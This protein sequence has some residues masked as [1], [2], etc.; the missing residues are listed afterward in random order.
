MFASLYLKPCSISSQNEEISISEGLQLIRE[1][2]MCTAQ[3]CSIE[4]LGELWVWESSGLHTRVWSQVTKNSYLLFHPE[5]PQRSFWAVILL[6][7]SPF[8]VTRL[9]H[10]VHSSADVHSLRQSPP[11]TT[12][13]INRYSSIDT[14][15][16]DTFATTIQISGSNIPS[17]F[18]FTPQCLE[19]VWDSLRVPMGRSKNVPEGWWRLW[20]VEVGSR[21]D[22]K[23]PQP[24]Q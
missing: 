21:S 19:V 24:W 14:Q 23:P 11:T 10:G 5:H 15:C 6:C 3:L 9:H 17:R 18:K 8:V 16:K 2:P 1:L 12:R 22:R 7:T 4:D 13:L 20:Q